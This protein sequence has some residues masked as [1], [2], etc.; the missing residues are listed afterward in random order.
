M[1]DKFYITAEYCFYTDRDGSQKHT[2]AY[3]GN[4]NL[5][6]SLRNKLRIIFSFIDY[7][8]SY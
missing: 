1:N 2:C 7:L 8:W 5:K 6:I 3:S 4:V